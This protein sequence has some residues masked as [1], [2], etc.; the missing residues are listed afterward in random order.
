[1]GGVGYWGAQRIDVPSF[2]Q[3][4][5]VLLPV[6]GALLG[7]NYLALNLPGAQAMIT[8]MGAGAPLLFALAVGGVGLAAAYVWCSR[9]DLEEGGD[10][11]H[12]EQED[13][14][15]G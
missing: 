9:S 11:R 7:Y 4:R 12:D 6:I 14:S 1:M 13:S 8:D 3:I 10:Q 5:C 15:T 2:Y